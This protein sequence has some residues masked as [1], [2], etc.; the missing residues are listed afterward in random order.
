MAP[1]DTHCRRTA[2]TGTG[3]V[4]VGIHPDIDPVLNKV[5]SRARPALGHR[6]PRK[7]SG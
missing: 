3:F 7:V 5:S 2:G 6:D 4:Q 1:V